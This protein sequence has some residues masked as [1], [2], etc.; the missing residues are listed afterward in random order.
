MEFVA[1]KYFIGV[2]G[3]GPKQLVPNL[4]NYFNDGMVLGN[5]EPFV[6]SGPNFISLPGYLEMLRG[7]QSYDCQSNFC[8]PEHAINIS[9]YFE[10]SAI[11]SSWINIHK[12][13]DTDI[14][15]NSRKRLSF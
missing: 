9:D 1:K 14:Y 4:Y 7:R 2:H 8:S 13:F 15:I 11:F 5:H 3:I 10:I 12:I 6:A